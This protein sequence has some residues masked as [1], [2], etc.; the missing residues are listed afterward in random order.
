MVD[1]TK[2]RRCKSFIWWKKPAGFNKGYFYEPTIF[3]NI[4]DN[5]TI[6]NEEPFGPLVPILSFKDFD[7]V[8]ERANKNDLGLASYIYTNNLE[9]AHKA[10]ELMETGTVAV[11]TGVVALTRGSFWGIKQTGYGREG[12]L[13]P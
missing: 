5:Y 12:G 9:K 4:K 10:S 7:E 2:K 8:V 13:W 1:L 3:D 11:N 6:M